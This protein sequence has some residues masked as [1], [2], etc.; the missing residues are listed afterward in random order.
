MHKITLEHFSEVDFGDVRRGKRFVNII[1]NISSQPGASIPQQNESWYDVKATYEFFKNNE[2][3][4]PT[5]QKALMT[6]GAK[7]VADETSVLVLH[8]ISNI[9]FYDLQAK[10]LGYLDSKRG[11][12]IL[13]YSS[14][15][16]TTDG[17]PLSLLYQH[18]WTRPMEELGKGAKRKQRRF[19]DKESYRW[20]EGIVQTNK[21]LGDSIHKIHIADRQADIYDV[22]F[23]AHEPNTDL[24]IR[25][26]YSRKAADGSPLW[27]LVGKQP[28]S[29]TITLDIPDVTGK[30]KQSVSAEV[31][32][33][34]VKI[35]RPLKSDNEYE[36]VV[37]TAIEVKELPSADRKPEDRIDWKLLTTIE[38]ETATEA[39]QC[40]KWYTFR[41]LIERFH[42]VLKSGTKIETLQLKQAESLQK[43]VTVY[44]MAA[45]RI[46]QLV[47]NSRHH[48]DLSCE[49]AL[50]TSQWQVLFI[51][52]HK[53]R[54]A[55]SKPP[56]LQQA[57]DWIGR[58]GG[59]LGRKADG[60]PGLKTVWRG[61]HRLND[62]T[63][64]YEI[65]A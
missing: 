30:K 3:S 32:Y 18:T 8:D 26:G 44:S 35:L 1:N 47:Y 58:L 20:Y 38:V 54:K 16:A 33:Q 39:L 5:L 51:L 17:L 24:L 57:V 56:T 55:P 48:P 50:T 2:V 19:E 29:A 63:Q 34:Q 43:A 7:Q 13:S 21:L 11:R 9:S 28:P 27:E 46:M 53:K 15:A 42:Y 22:F 52:I 12:G 4:L 6:Y 14:I 59:H 64:V 60:P 10:G 31:R 45:F 62:A 23:T 36:S 49:V 61:Y 65:A 41:W 37:L 25:A 40:V